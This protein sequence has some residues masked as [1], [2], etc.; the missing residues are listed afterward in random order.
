MRPDRSA[1]RYS[2]L[3][4]LLAPLPALAVGV[5]VMRASGVGVGAW[6]QNIAAWVIGMIACFA[7][8]RTRL[9]GRR[10]TGLHVVGGVA[11]GCLAATLLNPGMQ[12]VHRWVTLGPIRLHA[13]AILLPLLLAAVARLDRAR[14]P[15]PAL[16]LAIGAALVLVAQPD[17]AQAT[18][19]AAAAIVVLL[20]RGAGEASRFIGVIALLALAGLSWL[21]RD[22]LVEVPHVEG[23]VGLA[24]ELGTAWGIA[25]VASL[26]LLPAPFFAARR[27]A[28]DR[29]ALALGVYVSVTILVTAVGAFPVPVLGYGASP[30]IGYFVAM[31][32]ALRSGAPVLQP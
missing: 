22:P 18:A 26:L 10:P 19:F 21:R 28:D 1:A 9:P 23:I 5:L 3:L 11:L 2:S 7:V 12:D 13:A 24:A 14:N 30:I 4:Y 17:A 27:G 8:A 20:P 31:G 6:A 29:L 15:V 32:F 16:L 25:A